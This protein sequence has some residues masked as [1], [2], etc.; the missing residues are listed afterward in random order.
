MRLRLGA[1]G[2]SLLEL[3]IV[4]VIV[5]L[6]V[7][8]SILVLT[9]TGG[10]MWSRT[11]AQMT[12]A[13]AAQQALNRLTEDARQARRSGL[14]CNLNGPGVEVW[15][16][17]LPPA[18]GSPEV[19]YTFRPSDPDPLIRRSLMRTVQ[20]SPAQVVATGITAFSPVNCAAG[21]ELVRISLTAQVAGFG[22]V[23]SPQTLVSQM[24]VPN[25]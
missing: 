17:T 4:T 24:W 18:N 6:V 2:V 25:P 23:S 22:G 10:Q 21:S 7:M 13:T 15:F 16:L 3:L 5:L 9:R 19:Q 8:G 12:S 11:D 1:R 14:A 20:G